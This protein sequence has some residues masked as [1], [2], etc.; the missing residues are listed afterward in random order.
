MKSRS[1]LLAAIAA[2][3]L[4][5][6]SGG[7]GAAIL[8]PT[9][10]PGGC[11]DPTQGNADFEAYGPTDVNVQAG[12]GRVTVNENDAGTITVFKYP[13]PSLYNLVK[14]FTL[15]RRPD[16]TVEVQYPNEGSFAGIRFRTSNG[17]KGF[18]WLRD[19][20][21]RQRYDSPDTPV[22]VTTYR[23]PNGL[24]LRV[25]DTDIAPP[26]TDRFVRE[27][28]VSRSARSHVRSA[29]IVYFA[30]FNPVAS[31]IPL[32]PI[33]DWCVSQLSDQ[34]ASYGAHAIVTS[35]SGVDQATGNPASIAVAFGFAG[36]DSAHQVGEDGYDQAAL[37]GGPPDAYD[38]AP[39]GLGGA[40][41]A[42]GQTTGALEQKLRFG[43][44]GR[45]VARMTIA[46]G[47]TADAA[48]A[49]VRRGRRVP[50]AP[51]MAR[52]R[53]DWHRF[54]SHRTLPATGERQ[55][56]RIAKRSLI[57]LRLARAARGGAIVAS[58]N[59]QG[60]Y[61]EDWIR[62]GAF[63]NR[64]LDLEGLHG[65]VTKHNLFYARVQAS[66]QNPSAIRP[67]GNWAMNSY[68]D[69]IDGA[70]IPWEIDET[71]LGA[72][73]LFDHYRYL[74]GA[75]ARDYLSAVYPAI[76]RAADFLTACQD[77]TTG[78]QCI[79]NEDDNPTPSQSLHGAAPV[80]LGLRSAIAAAKARGDSSPNVTLWKQRL[81]QIR[82]AIDALYDPATHRYKPGNQAGNS[83]NVDYGDGGWMLWPVAFRPY[84]DPRMVGEAKAV[85][86]A[87]KKS[88][89]AERGQ[90]EA[91]AL[92][93]LA[94]AWRPYSSKHGRQL[95][96]TLRYMARALPTP[97][98][99]FGESWERYPSG[100]PFPVQDQPHVWEHT[101]F[102]MAALRI[103][104]GRPYRFAGHG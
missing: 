75:A 48:L 40:D 18:A 89:A 73:T 55:V 76:R 16:G 45:A 27:F 91:K 68:S 90:Y 83:Y 42:T 100:H 32:L 6:S 79:A 61:G 71:G 22:P 53:R 36:R 102:L 28:R 77:P 39:S 95:R 65:W 58:V 63:I 29:S 66:P 9:L 59:T 47:P 33:S 99:L 15:K 17:R 94:H 8:P 97:T 57:T 11:D 10:G 81:A 87:M 70:P 93:G 44:H 23:S 13:D 62:D 84:D 1:V 24:G 26:H 19:W 88:L 104:G 92:L 74:H 2:F 101:L 98:G 7:A 35:W 86:A 12:N 69:G 31:H 64:L 37:P 60:P 72:W 103:D 5:A 43:A 34:S 51:Q 25:T 3:V 20:P 78:L 80:E 50:F 54:L 96:H 85:H 49:A 82:A 38:Q 52:E 56:T 4:V 30:N 21:A 41:S 46:G 14:Y 67:D